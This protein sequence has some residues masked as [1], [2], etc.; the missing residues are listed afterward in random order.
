MVQGNIDAA[1]EPP[2]HHARVWTK[3]DGEWKEI[4]VE[5]VRGSWKSYYQNISDV[6]NKGAELAVKPEECRKCMAVF[7]AAMESAETGQT[8]K[9]EG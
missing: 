2:E 9:V 4:V 5:P 6:L 3:V 8:V 7:D 1:E